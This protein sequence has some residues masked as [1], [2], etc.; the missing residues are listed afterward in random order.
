MLG[1]YSL[2]PDER[3]NRYGAITAVS[4]IDFLGNLLLAVASILVVF[5][6][7]EAGS[8]VWSWSSPVIVGALVTSGACWILLGFW[9]YHLL[10]GSSQ[11]IQPIFPMRLARN[12]V[13]LLC[14]LYWTPIPSHSCLSFSG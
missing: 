9:E 1:I 11:Q 10:H 5:A 6:L 12:R 13:Y 4:K 3:R 7:Q 2:W 14:L 8:F